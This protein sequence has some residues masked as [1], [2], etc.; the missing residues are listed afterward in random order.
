MSIP[1]EICYFEQY[2]SIMQN[3]SC[4][5]QLQCWKDIVFLWMLQKGC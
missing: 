5:Q 4:K 3:Q 1:I 2:I